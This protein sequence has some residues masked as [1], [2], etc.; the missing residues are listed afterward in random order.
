MARTVVDIDEELLAE[1]AKVL[2][3]TTKVATIRAALIA[4]VSRAKRRKF[5]EAIQRGE[6][7]LMHDNRRE[8]QSDEQS[9]DAA[10]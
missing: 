2:G 3:T 6:Y 1:A 9:G 7:D 4:E 5:A 10:A 8:E